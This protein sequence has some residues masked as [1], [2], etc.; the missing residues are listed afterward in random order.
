[1]LESDTQD[2]V[3]A[4]AQND[5]DTSN[6]GDVRHEEVT[7]ESDPRDQRLEL[8]RLSP[9]KKPGQK[10]AVGKGRMEAD[11]RSDKVTGWQVPQATV[12]AIGSF[13]AIVEGAKTWV[14]AQAPGSKFDAV[15]IYAGVPRVD[16]S[17]RS[18]NFWFAQ[19]L[20][21]DLDGAI[22]S[23][24]EFDRLQRAL[25]PFEHWIYSTA[26]HDVQI[27]K[28]RLRVL[29]PMSVSVDDWELYGA[30]GEWW[31]AFVAMALGC[32]SKAEAV[33]R[34][35]DLCTK[36]PF[37]PMLL[38]RYRD[39]DSR[40]KAIWVYNPGSEVVRP[41]MSRIQAQLEADKKKEGRGV[42]A[43]TISVQDDGTIER[44]GGARSDLLR[45]GLGE[46][47][48]GEG[49]S[50]AGLWRS[51]CIFRDWCVPMET[52]L[53]EMI[54]RYV[55]LGHEES[56]VHHKITSAYERTDD[57]RYGWRLRA[58][59]S[60]RPV[61][62]ESAV[63]DGPINTE[64]ETSVT[65]RKGL[66]T[67]VERYQRALTEIS[68]KVLYRRSPQGTG[69]TETLRVRVQKVLADQGRVIVLVHRRSLARNLAD[70]LGLPCYLDLEGPIEGSAV[71]CLDSVGRIALER[72]GDLFFE[73]IPVDLLIVDESEQVFRHMFGDTCLPRFSGIFSA[74]REL[75]TAAKNIVLQ[76]ADLGRVTVDFTRTFLGW[77]E[78]PD[79]R[80]EHVEINKW[81]PGR[82]I[83]WQSDEATQLRRLIEAV[84]AGGHHA[85]YSSSKKQAEG[86]KETL[87]AE[88]GRKI[89]LITAETS[90]GAE[91]A[92]ALQSPNTIHETWDVVIYTGSANT[93][94]S[95][96]VKGVWNVWGF[97]R[98]G[99]GPT[100][101]DALQGLCRVRHPVGDPIVWVGGRDNG[102][103]W[104]PNPERVLADLL[105]KNERTKTVLEKITSWETK[106]CKESGQ[107]EIKPE[108]M[109]KVR[110]QAIVM[111]DEARSIDMADA[112]R[113]HMEAS[114]WVV[115]DETQDSD[116][117][118]AEAKVQAKAG[119]EEAEAQRRERIQRAEVVSLDEARRRVES[120]GTPED[121]A[122]LQ[123]A[124]IRD[125][126]G[127]G[128]KDQISKDLLERDD[129]GRYR[130]RVRTAVQVLLL[131]RGNRQAV[132]AGAMR[133]ALADSSGVTWDHRASAADLVVQLLRLLGITDLE[134][135]AEAGTVLRPPAGYAI[136]PQARERIRRELGVRVPQIVRQ[137]TGSTDGPLNTEKKTSVDQ[138]GYLM[139]ALS[140]KLGVRLIGTLTGPK[141]QQK[142]EYRLD[143]DSV[144]QVL[145]DGARYQD[146]LVQGSEWRD[147]LAD[148][149]AQCHVT[150]DD[151]LADSDVL[152]LPAPVART[153]GVRE[154]VEPELDPKVQVDEEP[155]LGVD[156]DPGEAWA[157][158]MIDALLE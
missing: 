44:L 6:P 36:K 106:Y 158:E 94:I 54:S 67:Y 137:E 96:D 83:R 101:E 8:I 84:K 115:E 144:R 66:T 132:M 87:T 122:A 117:D 43:S 157:Q 47:R 24:E 133:A 55:P 41:D 80:D 130:S 126:Y 12:G 114:G 63:T 113:A 76:D 131:Q 143:L 14:D 79:L 78:A 28:W 145:Q 18:S 120:A 125:F 152:D 33:Q 16:G 64:K 154:E 139:R 127:I 26:S 62:L 42:R 110:L 21:L 45:A 2:T 82:T 31:L 92:A 30:V 46:L 88:T 75:F 60:E 59:L 1:M 22:R 99:S 29:V 32:K 95:I 15:C 53:R 51:A 49:R 93:G 27:N 25:A 146:R 140:A 73:A 72:M 37:Q 86:L 52:A 68:A 128:R 38:P 108:N 9:P 48:P 74:M 153:E 35:L 90:G 135:D 34:G 58:A 156:L 89:G 118:R 77:T 134:K 56:R 57:P 70:R 123:A 40:A 23:Q 105:W 4:Q 69:K 98:G 147:P 119:R 11:L 116:E 129:S 141:G 151:L 7:I 61:D 104:S 149:L 138:W 65:H 148:D 111:A 121:H 142:R 102:C 100:A 20:A 97:V 50:D 109:D 13:R 3:T 124:L 150:V 91:G 155:E 85:I 103:W 136:D 81:K 112:L 10:L 5:E 19:I 39:E 17:S 71:V 107:P